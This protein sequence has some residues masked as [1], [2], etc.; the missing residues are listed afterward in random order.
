MQKK[1]KVKI[2]RRFI[3][4]AVMT[5][6]LCVVVGAASFATALANTVS[7]IV[8]DGEK[9]YTFSMESTELNDIIK[10]AEEMGLEPLGANDVCERVGN[11]TAVNVRRGASVIVKEND[12]VT[13]FI[14]YKGDTVEKTLTDNSIIIKDK[15]EISPSKD[16]VITSDLT[17]EI[18]RHCTVSVYADDESKTVSLVGATVEDAIKA[19]GITVGAEDT[20]SYPMDKAL[21]NNMRIKVGRVVNI[22]VAV[23]GE[24]KAYKV[25]A[26]NVEKALQKANVTLNEEDLVSPPKNQQVT[27]GMLIT[28]KRVE[29]KE[30]TVKQEIDFAAKEE[31]DNGIYPEDSYVRQNGETGEKEIL[32]KKY[33]I[34]G[35]FDREE[36]ISE[37]T[38]KEPVDKITVKGT[39]VRP[40]ATPAPSTNNSSSNSNSG[41][42]SSGDIPAHSRVI[43]GKAS[44]YS[45]VGTTASGKYTERGL[46]A[47]DPSIIP[48]GTSLYIETSGGYSGYYT[49]AD[50]GGALLSG[51]ILVDIWMGSDQECFNFGIQ[52]VTVYVLD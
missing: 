47:V 13:E 46:V 10:K 15:D 29:I 3:T 17:V 9:I 37:K 31:S 43:T 4:K 19:A 12:T 30:E 8:T 52:S 1:S 32:M 33:F 50:T 49:A 2:S 36:V 39:K 40:V 6:T 42:N 22:S 41:N 26:E 45:D 28:V 38:V 35:N 7:T 51:R 11:T 20:V 25:S 24:T 44:A 23:D 18:K 5:F 21:F 34:D 27:E 16:S 48:Y 14:A